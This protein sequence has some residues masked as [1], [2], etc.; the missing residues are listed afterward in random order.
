MSCHFTTLRK[1]VFFLL[2]S[3]TVSLALTPYPTIIYTQI[4]GEIALFSKQIITHCPSEYI[5]HNS[6]IA[7]IIL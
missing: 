5:V 2:S 7:F 4:L 6:V 3:M 1:S